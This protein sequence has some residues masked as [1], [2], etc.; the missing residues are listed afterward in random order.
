ML[1]AVAVVLR[2]SGEDERPAPAELPPV[3]AWSAAADLVS[4]RGTTAVVRVQDGSVLAMGGG[5]GAIAL[6]ATERFDPSS[7]EWT[8]RASMAVPRRGHQA[9]VLDDG[10]VFVAGGIAETGLLASGELYDPAADRWTAAAPMASPRLGH[11]VTLL[12]D[13]TVLVTGGSTPQGGVGAASGQS[14]RP[15]DSAEIYDPATDRWRPA[16]NMTTARFE[17]TATTLPDGRV[18]LSGGLGPVEGGVGPVASA[19]VYDPAAGAFVAT[20]DLAEPRANHA[21]VLLEGGAVL[22]VGGS[23][24]AGGELALASAERF[25]PRSSQWSPAGALAEPRRGLTATTLA[26]GRVLVAGGEATNGGS[27]RSLASAELYAP[28]EDT[29]RSAADMTCPRSEH[30]SVLLDDG[31]VL[32]IA[33]DAAFPGE[34][35]AAQSCSD[36]YRAQPADGG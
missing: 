34:P 22:V 17:H 5:V 26:D 19:E 12:G 6:A 29:W 20:G 1:V 16:G 4:I 11:T 10:R 24:G 8:G 14:I 15:D 33:G 2:V 7:G 32:V 21:A 23:G 18:L 27:R 3:G 28:A 13:G 25:D 35:P 9:V 30:T 31:D 36:R